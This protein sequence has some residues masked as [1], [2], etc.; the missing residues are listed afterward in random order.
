M[1]C[2]L[3]RTSIHTYVRTYVH[4]YIRTHIRTYVHTYIYCIYVHTYGTAQRQRRT[5]CSSR[6]RTRLEP[7]SLQLESR[8]T[9]GLQQ[10]LL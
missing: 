8:S 10:Y 1:Q 7:S 6:A 2:M 9:L 3:L 5:H 4:T